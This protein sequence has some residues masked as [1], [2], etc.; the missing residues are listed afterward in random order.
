MKGFSGS[1]SVDAWGKMEGRSNGGGAEMGEELP[2]A[3]G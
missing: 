1:A 2:H 3:G